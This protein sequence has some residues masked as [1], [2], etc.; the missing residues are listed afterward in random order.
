MLSHIGRTYA[1]DACETLNPPPSVS[2]VSP[3]KYQSN[4][5]PI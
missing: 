1:A 3:L 5:G 4:S 2:A